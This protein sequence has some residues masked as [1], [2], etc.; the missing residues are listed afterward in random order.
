MIKYLRYKDEFG[1]IYFQLDDFEDVEIL[2]DK[3]CHCDKKNNWSIGLFGSKKKARCF[4]EECKRV[5]AKEE[6]FEAIEQNK[7]VEDCNIKINFEV[8]TNK[9]GKNSRIVPHFKATPKKLFANGFSYLDGEYY[10]LK[11]VFGSIS[12]DISINLFENS[13]EIDIFDEDFF[14][15]YDYQHDIRKGR[16][17]S[18][19]KLVHKK[20]QDIMK[21]LIDKEIIMGYSPNDY[22]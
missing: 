12:F 2:A 3:L 18:Y 22:I 9:E 13:V 4:I 10:L 15:P 11:R 21:D 7:E 19:T 1:S 5:R 8:P 14:Q 20:V 16:V 17:S 6:I